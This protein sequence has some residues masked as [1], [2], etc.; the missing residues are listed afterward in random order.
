[1]GNPLGNKNNV[2]SI[3]QEEARV[4]FGTGDVQYSL[5]TGHRAWTST[6]GSNHDKATTKTAHF[7]LSLSLFLMCGKIKYRSFFTDISAYTTRLPSIWAHPFT[8]FILLSL[9]LYF[10]SMSSN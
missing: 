4:M 9:A 8:E 10:H 1:M 3:N 6:A 2:T 7:I 5:D